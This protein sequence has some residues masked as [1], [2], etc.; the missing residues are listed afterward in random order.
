MGFHGIMTCIRRIPC[1]L[2]GIYESHEFSRKI[3]GYAILRQL[4]RHLILGEIRNGNVQLVGYVSDQC[5]VEFFIKGGIKVLFQEFPCLTEPSDR[6]LAGLP[7]PRTRDIRPAC[8][9]LPQCKPQ[10][11]SQDGKTCKRY[12]VC[13]RKYEEASF[14][15]H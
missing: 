8:S 14:G 5:L 12:P 10:E 11:E 13:G 9:H 7:C 6:H 4:L 15:G 3:S 1:K 2:A